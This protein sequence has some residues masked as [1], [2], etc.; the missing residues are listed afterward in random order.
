MKFVRKK[1]RQPQDIA[2]ERNVSGSRLLCCE[3]ISLYR[4]A[5]FL[6]II[7]GNSRLLFDNWPGMGGDGT[8]MQIALREG[9]L[10]AM[11]FEL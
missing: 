9:Y 8:D 11:Y 10:D 4:L 2:T 6:L 7:R 3:V 5:F 1:M